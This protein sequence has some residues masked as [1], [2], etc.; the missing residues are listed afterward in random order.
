MVGGKWVGEEARK[1]ALVKRKEG[2]R[3]AGGEGE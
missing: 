3:E 2:G 1:E